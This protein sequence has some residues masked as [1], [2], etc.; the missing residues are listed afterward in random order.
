MGLVVSDSP[1]DTFKTPAVLGT[2]LAGLGGNTVKASTE[3]YSVMQAILS[4][5][6]FQE[7]LM[8]CT[9]LMTS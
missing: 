5:R 1:T 8:R 2:W 7:I 6:N 9:R 4:T 3:H